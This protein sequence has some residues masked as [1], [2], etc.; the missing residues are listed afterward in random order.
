MN[1]STLE[2]LKKKGSPRER[3]NK[4]GFEARQQRT[5]WILRGSD[6]GRYE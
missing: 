1:E 3:L 4:D 5:R 2:S 6:R